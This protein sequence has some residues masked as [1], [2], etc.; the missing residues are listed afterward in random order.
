MLYDPKERDRSGCWEIT[1]IQCIV[2]NRVLDS[3]KAV[4]GGGKLNFVSLCLVCDP[5]FIL[6]EY[7]C[8]DIH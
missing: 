7:V 4:G 1:I 6:Q 5:P 3:S 2:R 8:H